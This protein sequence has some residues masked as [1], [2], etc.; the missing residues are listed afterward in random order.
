MEG[1]TELVKQE[2]SGMSMLIINLED[3][4]KRYDLYADVKKKLLK[5]H[6]YYKVKTKDGQEKDAIRKSGWFKFGVAFQ[7]SY[8]IV[9]E[10][11]IV[12]EDNHYIAFHF[13]VK[14]YDGLRSA[15]ATGSC[16]NREPKRP[17]QTLHEIRA[18]AETRATERAIIKMMG[19]DD[20]AAE[21][22]ENSSEP[23]EPNH[24]TNPEVCH[25]DWSKMKN[26]KG[27]CGNCGK[28]LTIA[29][30]QRLEKH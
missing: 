5:P 20:V 14:A 29:Q 26:D 25:C 9:H 11:R 15:E 10:E 7:L 13:T 23:T 30:I 12:D 4:V 28:P 19:T 27:R 17:N 16:D 24:P 21:D 18:M 2:Q 1:K 3:L 22:Y 8:Q 6:D